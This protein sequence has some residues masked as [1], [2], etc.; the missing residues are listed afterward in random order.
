MKPIRTLVLAAACLAAAACV[1]KPLKPSGTFVI[2]FDHGEAR[3]PVG[4]KDALAEIAAAYKAGGYSAASIE[5]FSDKVSDDEAA[6]IALTQKR[7]DRTKRDLV[8]F[9]VPEA[10]ITAT[11]KGSSEALVPGVTGDVAV[12]N[13]RCAVTLS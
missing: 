5:C 11:G 3:I 12:S 13:R 2:F 1:S 4:G 7:A 10:A 8:K 6:N 9:G